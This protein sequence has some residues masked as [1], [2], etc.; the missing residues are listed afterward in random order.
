MTIGACAL[1]ARTYNA[2]EQGSD[3]RLRNHF[4]LFTL[5]CERKVTAPPDG[6][7]KKYITTTT[8]LS[9]AASLIRHCFSKMAFSIDF[10]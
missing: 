1:S 3:A 10:L 9:V 8:G 6:V 2:E 7:A 5:F 4:V